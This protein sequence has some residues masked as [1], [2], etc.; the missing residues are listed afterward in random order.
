MVADRLLDEVDVALMLNISKTEARQVVK[1]MQHI[2]IGARTLRVHTEVLIEW[3]LDSCRGL[4]E[5]LVGWIDRYYP[6]TTCYTCGGE[7]SAVW[8]E[9]IDPR[10]RVYRV[11]GTGRVLGRFRGRR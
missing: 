8:Q 1:S 10:R 2:R 3:A 5:H 11:R 4:G 6:P 9:A 7:G